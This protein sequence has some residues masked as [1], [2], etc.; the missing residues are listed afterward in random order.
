MLLSFV[1][2]ANAQ[3]PAPER[4]NVVLITADDMN[5]DSVGCFGCRIPGITPNIDRLAAQG[6]RF[7]RAHVTIAV[8]QPCRSV[9]MTG[10]YPHRN[11]AEGFEPISRRVPT[12]VER[13]RAAGYLTGILGKVRHLAPPAK[14]PWD[15]RVAVT[16]LGYGRDPS[17]YGAQS[18]KFFARAKQRGQPFFLMANSHD[19]HRPFAGSRQERRRETRRKLT[20]PK[21]SRTYAPDEVAVPGFLPDIP[22]VR[23]EIAQ[24]YTS[25]HRADETV[26]AVLDA[27]DEAG[28]AERTIVMFLSDHGMPLPFA[29]TNCYLHSTK[30]PWIV[31][32]P[33]VV[34]PGKVDQEHFVSGIDLMPTILD[35][36]G[37]A[38]EKGVDGRS[39]VDLLKGGVDESRD[40][41]LTV[42]HETAAKRRYEM[43]CIQRA[44]YCYILNAWSDGEVVFRNESQ[45]GLTFRAMKQAAASDATIAARVKLFQHRV[46]EELYDCLADPDALNNLIDSEQ[47]RP[48]VGQMRAQML[49]KLTAI[50]DPLR[51]ALERRIDR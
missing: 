32:W 16:E 29:K 36:V 41:V 46:P 10:C 47:H 11:G 18:A 3:E 49:E 31:R 28:V 24:Y 12:L 30:T 35:A 42:F 2:D 21:P 33:G 8:C 44:S 7:T 14:F 23:R 9:W 1:A 6:M 38:P 17:K 4:P 19:P 43:R 26:G 40:H 22:P 51:S 48:I 20:H 50:G 34:A 13:L 27:L 37:H 39:F 15:V 5:W 45:S 25:V